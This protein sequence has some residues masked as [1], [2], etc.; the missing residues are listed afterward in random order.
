MQKVPA[1]EIAK[2]FGEWHDRALNEPVFVTRYGRESVVIVSAQLYGD[3]VSTNGI[4][5][6]DERKLMPHFSPHQILQAYSR[7]HIGSDEA[8]TRLGL[9]GYR[10]LAVALADADLPFPGTDENRIQREAIGAAK[11]LAPYLLRNNDA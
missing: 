2:N 5:K 11:L 3:F 7:G 10:D 8:A 4:A 6:R 9:G 1:A